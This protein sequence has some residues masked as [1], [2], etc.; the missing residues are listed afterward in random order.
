[1]S[2]THDPRGPA[3]IEPEVFEVLWRLYRRGE[4][5]LLEGG[6]PTPVIARELGRTRT[7]AYGVLERLEQQGVVTKV[8]GAA[9]DNYRA[10]LSWAPVALLDGGEQ[11]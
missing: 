11:L 8:D 1:M 10:R 3:N 9:P 7:T 2:S 5:D 6:V 4:T